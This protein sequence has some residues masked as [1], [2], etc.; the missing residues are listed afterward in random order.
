MP[1]S[2]CSHQQRGSSPFLN[3]SP[4]YKSGASRLLVVH[5]RVSE[6]GKAPDL[7][8]ER[9]LGVAGDAGRVF[10]KR[11]PDD[12]F[13]VTSDVLA[14]GVIEVAQA[15][16]EV[17]S[18]GGACRCTACEIGGVAGDVA[19]ENVW[20]ELSVFPDVLSAKSFDRRV[21]S[22]QPVNEVRRRARN[23]SE[24]VTGGKQWTSRN[25]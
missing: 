13:D 21:P 8:A 22:R 9:L 7:L 3:L 24:R 23:H 14:N 1:S 15:S 12:V 5:Q 6:A 10:D 11:D 16:L 18:C 17:L 20:Q 2:P 19:K 4:P 25:R